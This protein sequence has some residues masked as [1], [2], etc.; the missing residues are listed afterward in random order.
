MKAINFTPAP[1]S[2]ERVLEALSSLAALV[3]RTINEVKS[4]DSDFHE[5]LVQAVHVAESS[6]QDE[7]N[8]HLQHT[9]VELRR[10]LQIEFEKKQ[11]AAAADWQAERTRLISEIQR[12]RAATGQAAVQRQGEPA[13]T[14]APPVEV[15]NSNAVINE[16]QRVENSIREISLLIEDPATELS[17]V[18]RKNVERAELE[19]YL[20]GIRYAV[21][22]GQR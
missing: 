11:A 9:L 2:T 22:G 19:S 3:E 10:N 1:R 4:L 8:Q 5:Q 15:A 7:A 6:I 20:R 18:I 17:T 14:A 13:N 21:T 16:I 12:L